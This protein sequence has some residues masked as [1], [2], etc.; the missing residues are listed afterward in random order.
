MYSYHIIVVGCAKA[1][2]GV[3]LERRPEKTNRSRAKSV[4]TAQ[5]RGSPGAGAG[6]NGMIV[7]KVKINPISSAGV[8]NILPKQRFDSAITRRISCSSDGT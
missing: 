8:R 3:K 2:L 4:V 5:K 1:N 7:E 6:P